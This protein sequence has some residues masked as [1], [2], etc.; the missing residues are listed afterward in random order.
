M[1][2]FVDEDTGSGLARALSAVGIETEYPTSKKSSP[3]K[4]GD[5]DDKWLP[6]A[7]RQGRLVLSRNTNILQVEAERELLLTHLIGV[8][9]LPQHLDKLELLRLVMKRWDWLL[10][11]DAT[12]P[13][14]FAYYLGATGRAVRLPVSP[15]A[16]KVLRRIQRRQSRSRLSSLSPVTS[17]L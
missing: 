8:V 4:L 2:V 3:I 13:R 16:V 17:S 11:V 7:G 14:P 5:G 6:F 10:E 12:V 15:A 1:R 9:F